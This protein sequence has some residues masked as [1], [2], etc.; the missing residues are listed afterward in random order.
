MYTIANEFHNI[1]PKDWTAFKNGSHS[2]KKV[3]RWIR[4]KWKK[5][6]NL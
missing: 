6:R 3:M 4:L 5:I 2:L 1:D